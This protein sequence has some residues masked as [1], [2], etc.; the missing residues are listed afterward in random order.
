MTALLAGPLG[1]GFLV[2]VA[3]GAF[4]D[5]MR[6]VYDWSD[7]TVLLW[8]LSRWPLGLLVVVVTVAVVL[9][10]APRRRQPSLSWLALGSGI[11]VTLS[12]L[13]TVMLAAYVHLNDSFGSVYG[14]LGGVFASVT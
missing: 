8:N 5:E 10:H 7:G 1:L 13:A 9:D 6:A 2:L 12:M 4:A 14:P 3:G 11:A